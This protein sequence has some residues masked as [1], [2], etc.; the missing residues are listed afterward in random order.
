MEQPIVVEMI[1]DDAPAAASGSKKLLPHL[2]EIEVTDDM[3]DGTK[4][5]AE[6]YNAMRAVLLEH[7]L[8][9]AK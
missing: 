8:M 4:L 9:K 6:Q 1:P 2:Q 3:V 5:F 7:K